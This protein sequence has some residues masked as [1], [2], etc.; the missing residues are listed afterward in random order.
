MCLPLPGVHEFSDS[1]ATLS[2]GL[3]FHAIIYL[4]GVRYGKENGVS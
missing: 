3:F 4:R 1:P 2:G